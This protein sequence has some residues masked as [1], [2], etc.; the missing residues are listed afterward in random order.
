MTTEHVIRLHGQAILRY[1][2]L[3]LTDFH[4]AED[5]AQTVFLRAHVK[6]VA[7]DLRPWLYRVAYNCCMDILRRRK[8]AASALEREKAY[9]QPFYEENFDHEMS[10]QVKRALLQLSAEDRALV[11][12]RLVDDYSYAQ[13][14]SIYGVPQA[15]LRK[16]YTR[17]KTRLAEALRNQ[18]LEASQ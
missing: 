12:S 13:L 11:I 5:A 8:R 2:H 3:L 14:E 17:A 10:P 7:G 18:G 4:E 1:C 15:T 16:R 6:P 9:V